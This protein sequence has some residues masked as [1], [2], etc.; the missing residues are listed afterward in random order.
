M[1]GPFKLLTQPKATDTAGLKLPPLMPPNAWITT[2]STVPIERPAKRGDPTSEPKQIR[3]LN[4]GA[5]MM[6]PTPRRSSLH[7]TDLQT[8]PF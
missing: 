8:M 3:T 5:L 7:T 1:P 4:A 2:K 6:L